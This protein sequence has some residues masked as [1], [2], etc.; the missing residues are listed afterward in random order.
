MLASITPLGERGRHRSYVVTMA[1][2][3]LGAVLA[4]AALGAALGALGAVL[5]GGI[6][7]GVRMA[8]LALGLLA[9]VAVDLRPGSAPGPRR[10]VDER[11]LD[12]FR[13]W[14]YGLGYGAQLG[15][16]VSTVVSSAATY[17]ALLAA[18]LCAD[19]GAGALIVG[20]YGAIRGLT[21]LLA[22]RV[23]S[24]GQLLRLHARFLGAGARGAA[25]AG[26]L[27]RSPGGDRGGRGRGAGMTLAAHAI[28]IELPR[29]WSGRIFRRRGGNATLH[30]ASFPLVLHDG[31]FGDASTA[32]MA[33]GAMFLSLAE[34][35][36][37]AGLEAGRGLFA[38]GSDR[39]PAGPDPVLD[40]GPR[41]SAGRSAR[42]PAVLHRG[43]AALLYLRRHR[44]RPLAPPPPAA[45]AGRHVAD[46][47]NRLTRRGRRGGRGRRGH[48]QVASRVIARWA[49]ARGVP[50]P[51]RVAVGGGEAG[52]EHAAVGLRGGRGDLDGDRV[53]HNAARAVHAAVAAQRRGEDAGSG[54]GP[55]R[56]RAG[57]TDRCPRSA[58]GAVRAVGRRRWARGDEAPGPLHALAA[59]LAADSHR[60]VTTPDDIVVAL[61]TRARDLGGDSGGRGPG[62][63]SQGSA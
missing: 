35:V 57:T 38:A 59:A 26:R 20:V 41:A 36:P 49:V 22:A 30:A 18:L 12:E 33:P 9:A 52:R 47:A 63:E 10:Q 28:A 46:P 60:R 17:V 13:G 7:S 25:T 50:D 31:E 45:A 27:R 34:Y 40:P 2:F 23:H 19:V 51:P 56:P 16:G 62:T 3:L 8:V 39:A 29:G 14:V 44:R 21:P 32:R 55:G 1:A 6:A 54:V 11:W 58:G 24:P 5:L 48:A 42:S 43:G 4:G 15:L 37:G 53:G 61:Q